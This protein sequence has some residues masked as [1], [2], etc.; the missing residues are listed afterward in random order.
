MNHLIIRTGAIAALCLFG[1]GVQAATPEHRHHGAHVHGVAELNVVLD[2]ALLAIELH[3]PAYNLVGFEHPPRTEADRRALREARAILESPERL[4]PLAAAAGCKPGAVRV[5]SPLFAGIDP[6]EHEHPSGH[7][8]GHGHG[9]DH[10]HDHQHGHEHG[11]RHHEGDEH[12]HRHGHSH[13]HDEGQGH[14][15]RHGDAHNGDHGHGHSH[16]H[17]HHG[18]HADIHAEYSFD[19]AQPDALQPIDVRVFEHFPRTERLQVQRIGRAGQDALTLTP[20]RTA[21]AL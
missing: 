5:D 19:C 20:D 11:S 17:N 8:Q 18:H 4:F 21:L 3:S 6:D 10:G 14:D 15:E 7:E 13:V 2:G 9:S 1:F 16:D 12:G